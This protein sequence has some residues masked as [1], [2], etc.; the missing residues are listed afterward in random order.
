[1]AMNFDMTERL[2]RN[3]PEV[4][5]RYAVCEP[6]T[7]DPLFYM[8]RILSV[9]IRPGYLTMSLPALFGLV[10]TGLMFLLFC[11]VQPL[12]SVLLLVLAPHAAANSWLYSI[13]LGEFL[14][15]WIAIV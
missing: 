9:G 10:I 4:L 5:I 12:I 2:H 6:D 3:E 13:A 14:V 11:I 1:M 15:L 7:L 8:V